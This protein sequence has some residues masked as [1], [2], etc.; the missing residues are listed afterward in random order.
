MYFKVDFLIG[1]GISSMRL[2]FLALVL[3]G[4]SFVFSPAPAISEEISMVP[5]ITVD[6]LKARLD[7]GEDVVILDVRQ[8]GSYGLSKY[9]IKGALRIPPREI[10][11]RFTEIAM[12]KEIIIY[13][14]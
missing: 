14:T 10:S 7:R 9:R 11:K 1:K 12:G 13:C 2:L 3:S 4:V 8:P 6:E 5:R